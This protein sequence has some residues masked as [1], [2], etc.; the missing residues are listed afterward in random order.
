[1]KNTDKL[2]TF[3]IYRLIKGNWINKD[4]TTTDIFHEP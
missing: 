1:M 4:L 3:S 2:R